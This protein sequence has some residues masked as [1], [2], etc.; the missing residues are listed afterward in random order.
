MAHNRLFAYFGDLH[1]IIFIIV[2]CLFL[3]I[4]LISWGITSVGELVTYYVAR[5]RSVLIL[6]VFLP[7]SLDFL[8]LIF[9][10]G[11]SSGADCDLLRAT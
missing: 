10:A 5:N 6:L 7:L 2:N 1:A 8:M 11:V 9:G 3:L 4:C